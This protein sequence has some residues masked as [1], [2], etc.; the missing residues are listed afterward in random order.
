MP[1]EIFR[2]DLAEGEEGLS[3]A[4]RTPIARLSEPNTVSCIHELRRV[5]P[6]NIVLP[7]NLSSITIQTPSRV[8]THEVLPAGDN[9]TLVCTCFSCNSKQ[10]VVVNIIEEER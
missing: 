8:R 9:I 7:K 2:G 4:Y 5:N 10:E 3:L 1:Y 6:F